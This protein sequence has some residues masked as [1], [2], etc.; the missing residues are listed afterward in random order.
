MHFGV[1]TTSSRVSGVHY[2]DI[3]YMVKTGNKVIFYFHKLHKSWR[4]EKPPSFL[5]VHAYNYDEELRVSKHGDIILNSSNS[6]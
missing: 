4:K 1:L 3:R 6:S 5:T 2:L